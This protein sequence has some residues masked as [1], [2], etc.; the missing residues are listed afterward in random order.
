MKKIWVLLMC[1]VMLCTLSAC[2]NIEKADDEIIEEETT[3]AHENDVKKDPLENFEWVYVDGGVEIT[4]YTGSDKSVIVPETVENKK[5]VSVGNSFDGNIVI[6][7]LIVPKYVKELELTGCDNLKYLEWDVE[8]IIP[9]HYFYNEQKITIPQSVEEIVLPNTISFD[10][11]Y[12]PE[13]SNL[14]RIE[15]PNA[16]AIKGSATMPATLYEM[17]V[18]DAIKYVR[19]DNYSGEH[20]FICAEENDMYGIFEMAYDQVF[21]YEMITDE[22]IARIYCHLVNKDRIVVNGNLYEN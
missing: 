22:N 18:S 4:K 1:L 20:R 3:R 11:S 13:G 10:F 19:S 15:L 5:V 21:G 8:E 17:I 7:K 9:Y 2:K 6:E 12:I 14:K 16:K